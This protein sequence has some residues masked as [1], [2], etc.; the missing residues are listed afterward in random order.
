VPRYDRIGAT[1]TATRRTDP[2]IA[3][4][5]C[6]A[7]GDA[8]SV[9]NV[10]A[11]T[12]SYEPTDREV[13]AVEP[14]A[15]MIEK[16]S[17]DAAPVVQGSAEELPLD[18]KSVDAAMA[19]WT[20]HHWSDVRRGLAELRRVARERI[21]ILTW[22]KTFAG[23]F[24]LTRDYVPELDAWSVGAYPRLDEI[25]QVLGPLERRPVAVPGDCEDGFLR[26]WW[27]RPEA[28]LDEGVR[29]NISQ[30]NLVDPGAV[31][32]GIDRL[33]RDLSDGTWDARNGDLRE[34]AE[35]D[36]GYMLLVAPLRNL[37]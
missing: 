25:A 18:D 24:W 6:T 5:V 10:G 19:I 23:T 1:Y 15:T 21:V 2:R 32:R 7:L 29:R 11:G 30:F 22:D 20:I 27:A 37:R 9:V 17:A 8:G 16:R 36:L 13:I 26:A 33:G 4:A 3:A 35:L 14:S 34:L 12:G 28:Y 31:E